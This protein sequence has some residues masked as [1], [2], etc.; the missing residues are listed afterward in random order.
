VKSDEIKSGPERVAHRSLL[1]CLGLSDQDF[2]KPIIG[3]VNGFNEIIPGHIH[4]RDLTQEV[5]AGVYQAGGVPLE[6]PMI[7]VC[8][9]IVMGHM[10]MRYSL[11]SRELI[12]DSIELMARAHCF[13]GLVMVTNCDKID[14]ACLM[15]AARLDLPSVIVSG[16]AMLPNRY[17]GRVIDVATAFET[18]GQLTQGSVDVDE[19][20]A[21]ERAAC[22][23]AG[24]CAGLFTANSMN[25]MI[26]A[27]GMGLPFN[28]T[29][30]APFSE[31]RGLAREA[32][33]AV[34][35]LV[36]HNILPSAIMTRQAFLNAI[37]VDMA[38]GGSTNTLL[39]LMAVAQEVGVE[40]SLEDFDQISRRT[41]NLCRLSPSGNHHVVDLHEAGGIP[42]VMALLAE[43]GLVDLGCLSVAG[44]TLNEAIS[45]A[46]VLDKEVIHSLNDPYAPEG[47][48]RIIYGNLAPG[49]SIIKVSALPAHWKG[50]K[51]PARVFECE[52]DA[53]KFV[54]AEKVAEG[55]V[56]V[57]RNEGPKGGPGM[58]E[59]LVLTAALAGMGLSEKVMLITDGRFSGASRGAAVGHIVPEAAVGGPIAA[60]KD[61]DIIEL[62]LEARRL[63][64]QLSESE[65]KTRIKDYSPPERELPPGYL[66]RYASRVGPADKGAVYL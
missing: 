41:P 45:K 38:I 29:I 51:G 57:I 10:G 61:D 60:I 35:G 32:G 36:E 21:I 14:P 37:A 8:D 18:A 34:M 25:C 55:Q 9:G 54:F 43:A 65:I 7:G 15:A 63:T 24:S 66:G 58:R 23:T 1:R 64:L 40:L 49:G 52:E 6:F 17:K 2:K 31:R 42:A 5:K 3:V 62:D 48:L 44:S 47:G 50:H 59:M 16:G 20:E 4:L 11:P 30:P 39:H 46:A 19:A 26:E 53:A 13:D 22:P 56:L 12:A 28:G 33:L 27:L